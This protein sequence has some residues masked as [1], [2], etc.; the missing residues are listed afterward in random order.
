MRGYRW[1]MGFA[2]FLAAG[3]AVAHFGPWL[4]YV[5]GPRTPSE[6]RQRFDRVE[7]GMTADA[8]REILGPETGQAAESDCTL[9]TERGL[10]ACARGER[11]LR[12]GRGN[13]IALVGFANG[14]VVSK[15]LFEPTL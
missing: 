15:H 2:L 3:L 10:V 12:W 1:F 7:T 5:L 11:I 13:C 14:A 4:Y 8:V 9:R 6:L